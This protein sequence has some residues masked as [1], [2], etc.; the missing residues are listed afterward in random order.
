MVCLASRMDIGLQSSIIRQANEF[1]KRSGEEFLLHDEF[2][3]AKHYFN[4]LWSLRGV[5]RRGNLASF[6]SLQNQNFAIAI[7]A[8][9]ARKALHAGGS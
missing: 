3:K 7:Y 8:Q 2:V 1:I 9:I 5:K 4:T 6:L